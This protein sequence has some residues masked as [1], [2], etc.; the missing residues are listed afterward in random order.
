MELDADLQQ[1]EAQSFQRAYFSDGLLDILIGGFLLIWAALAFFEQ[2][3]FGGVSFALLMPIYMVLRKKITEPRVGVVKFQPQRQRTQQTKRI[4]MGGVFAFALVAG[5][6]VYATQSNDGEP[7]SELTRRFAPL[8]LGVM[9]ALMLSVAGFLYNVPR[10]FAYAVLVVLSFVITVLVN[11]LISFDDLSLA[12]GLS[13][14]A[15][16]SFG[17]FM[18]KQFTGRY[19]RA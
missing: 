3:G 12:L 1:I 8:P 17:A 7:P 11:H 16:L 18:L 15:P 9:F 2:A 5:V 10:A 6:V 13:C 4:L 19:T 14:I